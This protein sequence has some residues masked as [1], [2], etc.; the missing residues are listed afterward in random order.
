MIFDS[1]CHWVNPTAGL[2]AQAFNTCNNGRLAL[3]RHNGGMNVGFVD[4]HVK[5]E[6]SGAVGVA[7]QSTLPAFWDQ[8]VWN[9]P[10]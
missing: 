2:P 1:N 4:G 5:W 7:G 8:N 3:T 6:G 9:P 10:Q